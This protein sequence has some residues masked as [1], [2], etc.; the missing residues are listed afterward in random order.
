M[1]RARLAGARMPP[2]FHEFVHE[3]AQK[4]NRISD[5][6]TKQHK[7]PGCPRNSNPGLKPSLCKLILAKNLPFELFICAKI[8]LP[9]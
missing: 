1:Q 5:V 9:P 7:H 3:E 4:C 6:W 2:L 8:N